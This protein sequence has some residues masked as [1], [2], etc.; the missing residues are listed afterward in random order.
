MKKGYYLVF[1]TAV[2][3]G[4]AI[5]INQFGVKVISP[6]TFTWLK[7]LSV[8]ILLTSLLLVLK[9][10][11]ILKKLSKNQ[12]FLLIAIGLIGGSIPFLL[13]FKGLSLSTAAKGAFLHKTMF[14]Y[15][16]ILAFIFL[17]EKVDKRF[18]FGGLFLV[19]GN[20]L[21]FRKLSYSINQGDLLI[22][23]AT[24]FWAAENTISK[25]VLKELPARI[26]A[27]GRMFFGSLFIFVFLLLSGQLTLLSHFTLPQVG[28]VMI[29][30]AI[31]FGYVITWYSG[32]KYIPVSKAVVILLLGSPITTLLA[33]IWTGELS[34]QGIFASLLITLGVVLIFGLR[35]TWHLI[36]GIKKLI[37]VRT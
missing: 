9:D 22:L 28:W 37:Y 2:I 4:F 16:A 29:T 10:W 5:F 8:V 12:W 25:Y 7:N 33:F 26:V 17:K 20:L 31:L 32:L 6:Y 21:L 15:V 36:R 35:K 24:L 3:S 18:L 19:L 27:W 13:F 34:L 14:V 11:K 1:L 23:S 30:S